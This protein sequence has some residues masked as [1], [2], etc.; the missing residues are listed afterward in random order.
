MK[1]I[2]LVGLM[3]GLLLS[4]SRAAFAG[5]DDVHVATS[6]QG[7]VEARSVTISGKA[8]VFGAWRPLH[9]GEVLWPTQEVR[10]GPKSKVSLQQGDE[11]KNW[12]NWPDDSYI[13][14]YI[15]DADS[16]VRLNRQG[17]NL[18]LVQKLRGNFTLQ[19]IKGNIPAD[20]YYKN[21]T[22]YQSL[23]AQGVASETPRTALDGFLTIP[24]VFESEDANAPSREHRLF[25]LRRKFGRGIVDLPNGYITM[26]GDGAQSDVTVCLFR[27]PD[28]TALYARGNSR[29]GEM[30]QYNRNAVR[31]YRH[32]RGRWT[33]VTDTILPIAQRDAHD[34]HLPRYGTTIEVRE[35]KIGCDGKVLFNL[36][37]KDGGFRRRE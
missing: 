37:W 19:K 26:R 22:W 21:A 16:L 23:V 7:T 30:D 34:F 15:V 25:L 20:D 31:F 12:R 2:S 36:D 14:S 1:V 4:L 6:I 33:E 10:T 8:T 17:R 13:Y 9:V 35:P 24:G 18:P 5:M 32:T 28:G 11:I 29:V 3:V 27:S